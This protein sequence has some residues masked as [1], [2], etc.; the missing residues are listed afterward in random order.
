MKSDTQ[1]HAIA[2]IIMQLQILNSL[3]SY[4][5]ELIF[6]NHYFAF[7]FKPTLLHDVS[8]LLSCLI[9]LK[10]ILKIIQKYL[11]AFYFFL[12]SM[13]LSSLFSWFGFFFLA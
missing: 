10:I 8:K 2:F 1:A 12:S 7:Y 3:S 11:L 4:N 9:K 13:N 5:C 6:Q